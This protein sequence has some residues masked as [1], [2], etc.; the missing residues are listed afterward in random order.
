M[1]HGATHRDSPASPTS[2][3]CALNLQIYPPFDLWLQTASAAL[4]GVHG[5]SLFLPQAL[6]GVLSVALLYHLVQRASGRAA[7]L[8]A[9]LALALTPISVATSRN[10]TMDGLL[11]LISLLATWAVTRATERGRLRWLVLGGFLVGLGFE[12]KMLEAF[13]VLP[14]LVL[15]YLVAAPLPWRTRLAHL[16]LAGVVLLVVALAWPVAVDATPANLRP[17]VGSST[18]NSEIELIIG[19][20]GLQRLLPRAFGPFGGAHRPTATPTSPSSA[21]FTNGRPGAA[22]LGSQSFRRGA[23]DFENLAGQFGF[24]IGAR[25]PQRFVSPQLAGQIS[26]LVPL[27]MLG[28]VVAVR[29]LRR[30]GLRDR[31]S[32]AVILWGTWLISQGIFFSVASTFETY[33]LVMLAPA[34]AA[35]V[36]VG[37]VA[38]WR[39]YQRP[40][41]RGWL[42]PVALVG[43]AAF[44][45]S[46]LASVPTWVE[47]L[48]PP[49]AIVC[50]G[51][52]AVLV[53]ARVARESCLRRF[54]GAGVIAALLALLLAPAV[55]AAMP[56]LHGDAARPVAGP[57][58]LVAD[59]FGGGTL[60]TTPSVDPRLLSYLL[61][62]Q[63]A[64]PNLVATPNATVAAPIILDT[65]KPVMALGGFMGSDPILVPD[66]LAQLVHAGTVRFFLLPSRTFQQADL[67]QWVSASCATV[68][69]QQWQ[70]AP[71]Q[72]RASSLGR[73]LGGFDGGGAEQ[74]YDCAGA[75]GP[76]ASAAG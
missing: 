59:R 31:T 67:A 56:V 48:V 14:A 20:N 21:R 65:G 47:W 55:W 43:T 10:N 49:V 28:L 44:E 63:G 7:G 8:L 9:A 72:A 33:Y 71:A 26:W 75:A 64:T 38:L 74:L 34:I 6:A 66:Q 16:C 27:A 18:D 68:P 69:S 15:L 1:N 23:T 50:L 24:G 40:R 41:G 17:Y 35:L 54:A 46:I 19:H 70:S 51:A 22:S 2:P 62:N 25:G 39:D 30:R 13:L 29:Q 52:A 12:T 61:A 11:V 53:V 36:G 76:A 58:A 60:D 37:L 73:G 45:A 4:F 57:A 5:A 3:R 32:Q 42:L